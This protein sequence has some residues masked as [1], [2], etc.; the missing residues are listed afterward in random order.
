MPNNELP[1]YG[2]AE[3]W[4][5][6]AEVQLFVV[7]EMANEAYKAEH[8]TR[9]DHC[10]SLA[11]EWASIYT[12]CKGVLDERKEGTVARLIDGNVSSDEESK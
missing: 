10:L 1:A 11:G 6:C 7:L 5:Q 3:G 2:D 9:L 12:A 4:K 8:K